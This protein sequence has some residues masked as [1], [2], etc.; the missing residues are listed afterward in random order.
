[1]KERVRQLRILFDINLNVFS[2]CDGADSGGNRGVLPRLRLHQHVLRRGQGGKHL[3]AGLEPLPAPLRRGGHSHVQVPLLRRLRRL[4]QPESHP[5]G[6]QRE[7]LPAW[8]SLLTQLTDLTPFSL[9]Q[10]MS[11]NSIILFQASGANPTGIDP[12][13]NDWVEL[14]KA[15]KN[16]NL[17]PI[18][19]TTYQ[20]I[21][22][23]SVYVF[24]VGDG[25]V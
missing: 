10:K 20:G 14:S 12:N 25:V 6:H 15:V 3:T 9:S 21:T 4:F 16:A 8:L 2:A 19:D 17:L 22:S 13:L 5:R 11:Y 24:M 7:P 18:F 23:G 1:M